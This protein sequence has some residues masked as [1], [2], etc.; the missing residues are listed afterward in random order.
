[1][2]KLQGFQPEIMPPPFCRACQTRHF[3]KTNRARLVVHERGN[4][5]FV[6]EIACSACGLTTRNPPGGIADRSDPFWCL[7]PAWRCGACLNDKV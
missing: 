7:L 6:V 5:S 4:T 1:M 3:R 2:T